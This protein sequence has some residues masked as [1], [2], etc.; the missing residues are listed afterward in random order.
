MLQN[1]DKQSPIS[2]G[3]PSAP[4]PS[5]FLLA[6]L[7]LLPGL[8]FAQDSPD[9][10][11]QLQHDA[12]RSGHA[13]SPPPTAPKVKWVWKPDA[14]AKIGGHAQ[15]VL[16][17]GVIVIGC[18][19]GTAYGIN[20]A[21]GSK[22]WSFQTAAPILHTA[23]IANGL[24]FICSADFN[25]YA[26]DL[27]TGQ[28]RWQL[29]ADNGFYAAPAVAE[30]K[31]FAPNADGFIYCADAA[32]GR[33]LWKSD[34]GAPLLACVASGDGK[35]FVGSN[36]MRAHAIDAASGHELW[37]TKLAGESFLW[38][39][40]V[41][42]AGTVVFRTKRIYHDDTDNL[43][44]WTNAILRS[45]NDDPDNYN[46]S[47]ELIRQRLA[48]QLEEQSFHVLDAATGKPRFIAP[49][50]YIARH[51]DCPLP[52]VLDADGNFL[53]TIRVRPSTFYGF[54]FASGQDEKG[55]W[56][57]IVPDFTRLDLATGLF[58]RLAPPKTWTGFRM[59]C[60]D[61]SIFT[62]AGPCF[63]AIH[64]PGNLGIA[65]MTTRKT[66][67]PK[68]RWD[69]GGSAHNTGAGYNGVV[70]AGGVMYIHSYL[71]NGSIAALAQESQ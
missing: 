36:D 45:A 40:P 58:Q 35:V 5:R 1:T 53:A 57:S 66:F 24:A 43:V 34:C 11:P 27:N 64:D 37:S 25:L 31:V 68:L 17:R 13:P 50:A 59:C 28:K 54:S 51:Q 23:A 46:Q 12:A 30:G 62:T 63:V 16:S 42:S 71:G 55:Q 56:G 4:H 14:A 2:P 67:F 33:L 7:C 3:R 44:P 29:A 15:P 22:R 65:D 60:D 8:A 18:L 38:Y 19:D 70:V 61:M 39:W 32:T 26:L 21:D 52:P 9:D 69:T 10:W 48:S 47:Q 6:L 41:Y 49:V 20:A